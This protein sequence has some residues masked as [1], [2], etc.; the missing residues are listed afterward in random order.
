MVTGDNVTTAMAIARECGILRAGGVAIEGKD[1]RVM[2]PEAQMLLLPSLQVHGSCSP[3]QVP[4]QQ[5]DVW[6]IMY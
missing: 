1:F 5:S 2:T 4:I 6:K 3:P